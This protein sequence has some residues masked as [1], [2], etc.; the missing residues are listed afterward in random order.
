MEEFDASIESE[1][2]K[3]RET[4][5]SPRPVQFTS[6]RSVAFGKSRSFGHEVVK[7]L[8]QSPR[9]LGLTQMIPWYDPVASREPSQ[10]RQIAGCRLDENYLA[11]GISRHALKVS[12]SP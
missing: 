3:V 10:L 8:E 7:H 12:A 5:P 4:M 11:D 6:H 2:A 9:R 1:L